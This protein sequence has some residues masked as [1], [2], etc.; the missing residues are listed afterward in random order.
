MGQSIYKALQCS[1]LSMEVFFTNSHELGAALYFNQKNY[2]PKIKNTFIVPIAT[3]PN[4][5]KF[6]HDLVVEN[7]I[8][9][10]F[11]GAQH[12]IVDLS[13]YNLQN[14]IVAALKP[15]ILQLAYDKKATYDF[16]VKY[17]LPYPKTILL[18]E[19]IENPSNMEFPFIIKPRSSSSSRNIFT[20]KNKDALTHFLQE[21]MDLDTDQMITQA[22]IDGPEYTCGCYMDRYSNKISTIIFLRELGADGATTYGEIVKNEKIEKYLL[23]ICQALQKEGIEF[24]HINVQLR[25]QNNEP[26]CFEINGRLSSTECP[27][28]H[29]GFNSVDAYIHNIVLKKPYDQFNV[30]HGKKFLRY[31]EE[32][33]F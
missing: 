31:Y 26:F 9:I 18:K 11:S 14:P 16:F 12:E 28:A 22:Y 29:M 5:K 6:I 32:V 19:L 10:I 21:K 20:I 13:E 2:R 17:S 7:Q 4:Y 1:R 23:D 3:D 25:L 8:D 27:K 15:S 30:Q 33:Y 24:G